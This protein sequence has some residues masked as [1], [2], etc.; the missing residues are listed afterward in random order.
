MF[1]RPF[2]FLSVTTIL[3]L[4]VAEPARGSQA[5][6]AFEAGIAKTLAVDVASATAEQL[7]HGGQP[8]VG[9][10]STALHRAAARNE[11]ESVR[12]FLARDADVDA[13]DGQG[14]TALLVAIEQNRIEAA[15]VLL[16]HGADVEKQ[17]P[18]GISPLYAAAFRGRQ[19]CIELLV[20]HRADVN[21][22][23]ALGR[24]SLFAAAAEGHASCVQTLLKHGAVVTARAQTGELVATPL[25][26][27]AVEGQLDTA[28]LLLDHGADPDAQDGKWKITPLYLATVL[29]HKELSALL[30]DRGADPTVT[31]TFGMT[32][33]R[34]AELMAERATRQLTPI[35]DWSER[36]N[37][38]AV[39]YVVYLGRTQTG[40]RLKGARLA[41]AIGDGRHVVTA[42]HCVDD[43]QDATGDAIATP[44]L[45]S[46]H[47]GD[48]FQAEIVAA[49]QESDVALL[50]ARWPAHPALQLAST[51]DVA[52]SKQIGVA[53]YPPRAEKGR[54]SA[55][56]FLE[57]LSAFRAKLLVGK[58]AIGLSAA[59][60]IGPGWSGAP[61]ILP[62]SGEVAGVFS[63]HDLVQIDQNVVL[64]NLYGCD[65]Q[66]IVRLLGANGI[67]LAPAVE[68]VE[69]E[70]D[71]KSDEA[72]GLLLQFF[73]RFMQGD[74]NG[75]L[76]VA[77]QLREL[78]PTSPQIRLLVALA[79]HEKFIT[80]QKKDDEA[81]RTSDAEFQE[82]LR[83][84]SDNDD[85]FIRVAYGC[86]LLYD[87]RPAD[88]VEVLRTAEQ[89]APRDPFIGMSLLRALT[90][91]KSDEALTF[92]DALC[93][94]QPQNHACWFEYA[95]TLWEFGMDPKAIQAAKNAIRFGGPNFYRGRLAGV[96][97]KA[98]RMDEAEAVYKELL[99]VQPR[100]GTFWLWY[101][102]FLIEDRSQRQS[103]AR[104][105]LDHEQYRTSL[106]VP[107]AAI[108]ELRKRL[109]VK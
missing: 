59:R 15:K 86:Y 60:F 27:A 80:T 8:A 5:V 55:K 70:H 34:A 45:V 63:S 58:R 54:L 56:V 77:R 30:L 64:H 2:V 107:R 26:G 96:L 7:P 32:P 98:G 6:V 81:R 1:R 44:L 102:R 16:D 43:F 99:E 83:L 28:R 66:A 67:E 65:M 10:G 50:R 42:A 85:T 52:R 20:D 89:Q 100:E 84:L 62:K 49:D 33:A 105:A 101:A 78:R 9:Q 17:T 29:G 51:Q 69:S 92:G 4:A 14:R 24:T 75:K 38:R 11:A 95:G 109:D 79:A 93:R 18:N 57:D 90:E 88:A 74:V 35:A 53:G 73:E 31:D 48:V 71:A 40:Y 68:N 46:P 82:A 3:V 19:A 91:H 47:Y 97:A 13:Q 41:F 108:E 39:V 61:M 21:A 12:Q 36:L 106:T 104:R 37:P 72:F 103:D 76:E 94:Q 25:H 23:C 87:G 22:R